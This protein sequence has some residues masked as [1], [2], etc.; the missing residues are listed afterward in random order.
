MRIALSWDFGYIAKPLVGFRAHAE[1]VSTNIAAQH[2]V[3]SAGRDRGLL[4]S[5]I[6]FQR[7]MD[8]L[9][10][11]SLES[12]TR[13]RLQ[14]IATLQLLIDSANAGLGFKDV[15]GRLA[16]LVRSYP[17][18]L[19]RPAIWRLAIAQLGGRRARSALRGRGDSVGH[20]RP[21]HD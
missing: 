11:A 2:G 14:A 21:Q 6:N 12:E 8:F 15:A 9:D 10:D 19:A 16:N 1:T 18:L 4:Y 17:R 5:Q 3:T 20:R 7:R 13:K